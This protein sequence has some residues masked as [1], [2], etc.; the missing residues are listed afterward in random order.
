MENRKDKTGDQVKMSIFD[1]KEPQRENRENGGEETIQ[2]IMQE[3]FL[4]IIQDN[5]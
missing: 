1:K 3:K 4:E 5:F 2:E